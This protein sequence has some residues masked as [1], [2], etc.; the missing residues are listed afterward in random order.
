MKAGLRRGA[1]PSLAAPMLTGDGWLVRFTPACGLSPHQLGGLARAARRY[2]S[3]HIEVTARGGLQVRGLAAEAAPEFA[4]ALPQL[5]IPVRPGLSIVCGSLAGVDGAEIADPRPLASD[6]NAE[7]A[8]RGLDERLGPKVSVIVDGGGAPSLSELAADL[9]LEAFYDQARVQWL[10]VAGQR[11]IGSGDAAAVAAAALAVLE[12]LADE[13]A[14]KRVRHLDAAVLSR[15]AARLRPARV[16]PPHGT[17]TPVGT[18]ALRDGTSARGYGLAFGQTT[19]D[20]LAEFADAAAVAREIRLAPGRGLLVLGLDGANEARLTA[21]A[22]RLGFATDAGDPRLGII[23]CAGAPACSRGYFATRALAE[24]IARLQ[25]HWL[26]GACR[27]HLSGCAKRCAQPAGPSLTVLG[28]EAGLDLVAD[29]VM[30]SEALRAF[31]LERGGAYV[32]SRA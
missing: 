7:A 28:R 17:G 16:R 10:L 24:E 13:G 12:C 29:G 1:C 21:H 22:D 31:L 8:A 11:V 30:P 27:L 6:I 19:S 5:G 23:A 9:R 26:D 32:V 3:G 18:F 4:A 2:G 14:D 25:P 15:C 20:A